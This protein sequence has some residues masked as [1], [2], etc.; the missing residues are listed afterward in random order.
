MEKTIHVSRREWFLA[1]LLPAI[2][3]LLLERMLAATRLLRIP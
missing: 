1:A 3:L 2:G